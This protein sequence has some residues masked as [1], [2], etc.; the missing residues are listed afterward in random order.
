MNN[1]KNQKRRNTLIVCTVVGIVIFAVLLCFSQNALLG[2]TAQLSHEAD[3]IEFLDV[4]QGDCA[5]IYSN[6]YCAVID[7]GEPEAAPTL[8][9]ALRDYGIEEIDALII[10][11]LHSDHVGALPEIAEL[12]P[13]QN[14]FMPKILNKSIIAAKTGKETAVQNGAAFY[15]IDQGTNFKI[16]E[17][18]ITILSDYNESAEENHRSVFVMAEIDGTKILFT[19]DAE[20]K[21]E[22]KLLDENINIDCDILKVG[23]HGSNTSSGECFLSEATPEYAVIS[24][25]EDNSY[26]HPH[27]ET[28]N[29]LKKYG[30]KTFRTDKNGDVTFDFT[31]N[32]VKLKT[33]K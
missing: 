10:S 30:A 12:Y 1:Y 16:G 23:H 13:I 33:E 32:E 7:V 14:L 3:F 21:T 17:F 22:N 11:H 28:L 31:D 9:K 18:E 6:G 20:I 27:T 2:G 29:A 26:L 19:G 24:V 4:G 5:I 8:N 25:G 15:E